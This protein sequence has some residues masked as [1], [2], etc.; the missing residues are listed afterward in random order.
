M[1]WLEQLFCWAASR[2]VPFVY[3]RRRMCRERGPSPSHCS[4]SAGRV[5]SAST[6]LVR[7]WSPSVTVLAT[8]STNLPLLY[9]RGL[10]S[11]NITCPYNQK[12]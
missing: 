10:V 6:S 9:S 1:V 4:L 3:R 2:H 5:A 11:N 12:V 8:Q 7:G